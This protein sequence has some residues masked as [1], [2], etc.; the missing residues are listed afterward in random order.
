M[1]TDNNS[2]YFEYNH[3]YD[4]IFWKTISNVVSFVRSE[5]R[6]IQVSFCQIKCAIKA[7]H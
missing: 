2:N 6:A 5:P 7:V 4:F 1:G 3:V